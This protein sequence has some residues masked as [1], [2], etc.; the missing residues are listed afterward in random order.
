MGVAAIVMS[1]DLFIESGL[2][3]IIAGTFIYV[4]LTDPNSRGLSL[5]A[6]NAE[7]LEKQDKQ[8]KKKE[9]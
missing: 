3:I 7:A 1:R 5:K 9:S 6:V 4:F 8:E 2:L